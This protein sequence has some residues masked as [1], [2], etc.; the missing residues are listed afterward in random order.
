MASQIG[1]I[2]IL[3]VGESSGLEQRGAEPVAGRQRERFGIVDEH[4]ILQRNRS[5]ECGD[6][7][8]RALRRQV[9]FPFE[10]ARQ[11]AEQRF[12]GMNLE[13]RLGRC[14]GSQEPIER[15]ARGGGVTA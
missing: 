7:G 5:R 8:V 6:R 1:S 3:G 10:D 11:R 13:D 4:R 9:H 15:R 12:R 2:G 14:R